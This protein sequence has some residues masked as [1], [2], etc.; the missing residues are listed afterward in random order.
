MARNLEADIT[1]F[2]LA[3]DTSDLPRGTAARV[4]GCR[5]RVHYYELYL[6]PHTRLEKQ[7]ARLTLL[8]GGLEALDRLSFV[9]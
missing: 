7:H 9:D 3:V 4:G 1:P 2:D 8:D 6:Q 5:T